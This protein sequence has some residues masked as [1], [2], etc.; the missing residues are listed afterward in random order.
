MF[1]LSNSINNIRTA[2]SNIESIAKCPISKTIAYITWT[3][4]F[5]TNAYD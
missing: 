2:H 5:L 4:N 1:C 3:D